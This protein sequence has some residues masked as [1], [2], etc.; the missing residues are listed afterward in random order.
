[1]QVP[2]T[3]SSKA[4]QRYPETFSKYYKTYDKII[5]EIIIY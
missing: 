1:M 5:N 4:F 2:F 3:G